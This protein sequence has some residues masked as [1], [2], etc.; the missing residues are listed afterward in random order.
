M[1][2][3][4]TRPP[5][6][7]AEM[8]DHV[9]G[10]RPILPGAAMMELAHIGAKGFSLDSIGYGGGGSSNAAA[11]ATLVLVQS[12]ISRPMAIS[13]SSS[14]CGGG[15][16]SSS[17]TEICVTVARDGWL[18]ISSGEGG[19][20]GGS[21]CA[22]NAKELVPAAVHL[23]CGIQSLVVANQESGSLSLFSRSDDSGRLAFLGSAEVGQRAF[24]VG[25][26]PF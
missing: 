19:Y 17:P 16:A 8:L 24:W 22:A 15:G 26:S 10:G 3:F 6:D 14:G 23:E 18:T 21:G 12:T 25:P 4:V 11:A 13:A 7:V 9:V 1:M 5:G 20:N 2:R